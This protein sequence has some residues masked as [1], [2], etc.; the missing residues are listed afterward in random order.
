[1]TKFLAFSI[2]NDW[3][4]QLSEAIVNPVISLLLTC[5]VFLG[6]VYQLYSKHINAAGILS[7]I[8][9]LLLF[10]G[11]L[12][13]GDVNLH[14][15]LLFSIGVILVVIELFV[16][17]AV[18]GL[19]GMTLI[20]ISIITLG[21]NLLLMLGNVIVALIFT[22]IEWVILVKIFN[23]KIPFLDKVILKDSTSSEAGY[24]SQDNRSHLVG[25]KA[26]TVTDLRP[27]GI[28]FCE[29]ERIDAV[30]D[31]NFILRNKTVEI[32]EVEGSRV[33]VRETN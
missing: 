8:A 3:I 12:V 19:I 28:I 16:V 1:M 27:A 5:L 18:I 25:K 7:S 26:Q 17:G 32:L 10:F 13:Q 20:T 15:V 21:D 30:S 6:F 2:D 24:I 33:V 23:R 31:G 11:F 14:S 22:I 9:L 29:N 4:K